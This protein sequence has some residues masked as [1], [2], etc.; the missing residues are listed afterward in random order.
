MSR[1]NAMRHHGGTCMQVTTRTPKQRQR[2]NK[3]NAKAKK[4]KTAKL[5]SHPDADV[6][7]CAHAS[8]RRG[9]QHSGCRASSH[10]YA[11][12]KPRRCSI[13]QYRDERDCKRCRARDLYPT[14]WMSIAVIAPGCGRAALVH[15]RS[16][17]TLLRPAA[18]VLPNGLDLRAMAKHEAQLKS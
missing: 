9:C 5:T 3:D 15:I 10:L 17:C 12:T 8:R 11:I 4:N 2:Q 6:C 7:L 18:L 14:N 16:R 13:A 1:R